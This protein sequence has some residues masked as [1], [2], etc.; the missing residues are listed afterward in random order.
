[1]CH[2]IFSSQSTLILYVAM[3]VY[4][5][6]YLL[7]IEVRERKEYYKLLVDSCRE[8]RCALF[9]C[10]IP[11]HQHCDHYSQET[12]ELVCLF[13]SCTHIIRWLNGPRT[14]KLNS[15]DSIR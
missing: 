8:P 14:V 15:T 13:V 6:F 5:A 1:M 9:H 2:G 12:G 10:T 3:F 7:V 11:L 4:F